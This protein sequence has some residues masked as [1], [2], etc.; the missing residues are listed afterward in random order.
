MHDMSG[1]TDMGKL[2]TV[3]KTD[4]GLAHISRKAITETY[5]GINWIDK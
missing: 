5:R 4:K 2:F 3:D 1:R